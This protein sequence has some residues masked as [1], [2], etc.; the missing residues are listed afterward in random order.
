MA[1][2]Q[3]LNVG[4]FDKVVV[5]GR[6]VPYHFNTDTRTLAISRKCTRRNSYEAGYYAGL[7]YGKMPH[8]LISPILRSAATAALRR[9]PRP[10]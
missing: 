3:F 7:L 10:K 2:G 9:A 8:R 4:W 6:K 1:R 5:A